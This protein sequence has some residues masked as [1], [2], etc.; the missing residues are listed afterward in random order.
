LQGQRGAAGEQEVPA[1]AQQGQR[2]HKL[3]RVLLKFFGY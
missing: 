2:H 3:Q 1:H